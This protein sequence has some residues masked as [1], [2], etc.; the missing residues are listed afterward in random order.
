[1]QNFIEKSSKKLFYLRNVKYLPTRKLYTAHTA[2]VR[3]FDGV[4]HTPKHST[5]SFIQ[6]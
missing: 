1:M 4:A 2:V 5:N 3:I 6:A